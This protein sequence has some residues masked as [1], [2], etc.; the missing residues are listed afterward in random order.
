M[1]IQSHTTHTHV[2]FGAEFVNLTPVFSSFPIIH[3][4]G[5]VDIF[6][7]PEFEKYDR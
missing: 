6:V 2:S 1:D 7:L 5:N 3:K 4:V